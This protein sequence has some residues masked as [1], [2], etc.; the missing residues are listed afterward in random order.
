MSSSSDDAAATTPGA[1]LVSVKEWNHKGFFDYTGSAATVAANAAAVENADI[2]SLTTDERFCFLNNAYNVVCMNETRKLLESSDGDYRGNVSFC[3][4]IKFFFWTK[5]QYCANE[6]PLT[7]F[8]LE[9]SRLS[10]H[11]LLFFAC[12]SSAM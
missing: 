12:R 5:R 6:A 10:L 11:V 3:A 4:R 8:K 9:K 7:F 1:S 2:S